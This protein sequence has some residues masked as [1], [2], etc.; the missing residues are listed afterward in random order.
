M[1]EQIVN[2]LFSLIYSNLYSSEAGIL[3]NA[4]K[5]RFIGFRS[6]IEFLR[7]CKLTKREVL[8][9]GYIIPLRVKQKTLS[10]PLYFTIDSKPPSEY[11]NLYSIFDN[12]NF[13][14]L[15][16]IQFESVAPI[17][18]WEVSAPHNLTEKLP[19]PH[20]RV[21]DFQ[22][23]EFI[24]DNSES[25]NGLLKYFTP[26]KV[27]FTQ[28][29]KL[30]TEIVTYI[31]CYLSGYSVDEII[32]TYVNRLVFDGFIGMNYYK[33]I[34]S[35]IDLV[36]KDE[37]TFKL[38]EV[39]EKDLS[40]NHPIGFGI[41]IQRL[42][43]CRAISNKTGLK[44]IYI[45]RNVDNQRDRRFIGWR[46][47]DFEDFEKYTHK[48]LIKEGGMGMNTFGANNNPTI[49]VEEKYFQKI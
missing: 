2:H 8:N 25:L 17:E 32:G 33:G 10:A 42:K 24:Q 16:Y 5:N 30:N 22:G 7:L 48:N 14:K 15:L 49:L 20:F 37:A 29:V 46:F 45:V 9:G 3:E 11:R 47:I 27:K 19:I 4:L 39:K 23:G 21:F 40:K 28:N 26:K 1:Q 41:D 12:A 6:E 31:K 13:S 35:D 44:Y 18:K 34:P 36:I 43:D 38:Y